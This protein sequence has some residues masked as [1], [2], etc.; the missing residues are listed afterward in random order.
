MI[1]ST[2]DAKDYK[3]AIHLAT[4]ITENS[5]EMSKI[6]TSTTPLHVKCIFSFNTSTSQPILNSKHY[7]TPHAY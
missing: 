2:R 5:I 1:N 4:T 7:I 6:K 3:H